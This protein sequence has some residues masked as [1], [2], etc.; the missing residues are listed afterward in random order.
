MNNNNINFNEELMKLLQESYNEPDNSSETCLISNELLE[1]NCIKLECN[2]KFNYKH[3]YNEVY[4][5]K[6]HSWHSETKKVKA[7]QIKCPYC[8]NIQKGI[9]PHKDGYDKVRFVNWPVSLMMLPNKCIYTFVSGKRK[10]Q[11]CD[12]KCMEKYCSSHFKIIQKRENKNIEKL[13]Q[14]AKL[15]KEKELILSLNNTNTPVLPITYCSYKFKKGKNKGLNCPCKKIYENN[16]CKFH[17]NK[18]KSSISKINIKNQNVKISKSAH[19]AIENLKN[20]NYKK[21]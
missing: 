18:K 2:H 19:K 11:P 5:Q 16:M 1:D 9:L 13:N 10:S 3:I 15:K 7:C 20:G 14:I 6:K 8:R 17:N 12:K 4:K 21:K